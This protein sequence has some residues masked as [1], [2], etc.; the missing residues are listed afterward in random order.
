MEAALAREGDDPEQIRDIKQATFDRA[1]PA[2]FYGIKNKSINS[3]DLKLDDIFDNSAYT[4]PILCTSVAKFFDI[5]PLVLDT[6]DIKGPESVD[7]QIRYTQNAIKRLTEGKKYACYEANN[8]DY[9]IFAARRCLFL[10]ET[11]KARMKINTNRTK[12]IELFEEL[13]EEAQA[14]KYEHKRIWDMEAKPYAIDLPLNK[15]DIIIDKY[16]KYIEKLKSE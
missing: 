4:N 15:Y 13:L 1:Y 8:I 6:A 3:R 10:V 14:L 9:T 11:Y 2:L 5:D 12:G 16:K 7:K